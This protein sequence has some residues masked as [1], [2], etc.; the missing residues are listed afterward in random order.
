MSPIA[1]RLSAALLALLCLPACAPIVAMIGYSNSAIQIAVQLDRAKLVGD[2]MSYLGSGKTITDH[3]VSL[4]MG[5]NC[6]LINVV[7]PDP[8]CLHG[9][10]NATVASN[11]RLNIAALHAALANEENRLVELP[12]A[13][14]EDNRIA[15]RLDTA[16][17]A[18]AGQP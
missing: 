6:K 17:D 15:G 4:A 1:I 8:V 14:L 16:D 12:R 2:G 10:D 5:A 18:P 11:D 7:T 9:R 13:T 3:A